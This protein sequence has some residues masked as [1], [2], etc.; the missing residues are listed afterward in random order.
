MFLSTTDPPPV[1][2]QLTLTFECPAKEVQTRAVVRNS[3]FG[4]GMG[5]EF[6]SMREEDRN[7]VNALLKQWNH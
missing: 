3:I 6:K 5:V 1:G 7:Q 4:S 2:T